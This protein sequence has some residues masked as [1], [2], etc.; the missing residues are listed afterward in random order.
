MATE[1][2]KILNKIKIAR[3]TRND[4]AKQWFRNQKMYDDGEYLKK[5]N[6]DQ[7]NVTSE[8]VYSLV[9]AMIPGLYYKN[10]HL[11]LSPNSEEAAAAKEDIVLLESLTN[12]EWRMMK[13]KKQIKAGLLDNMLAGHSWYKTGY[14][15]MSRKQLLKMGDFNR[16]IRGKSIYTVQIPWK[17]MFCNSYE[18]GNF[19]S[20]RWVAQRYY[21]T[22]KELEDNPKIKRGIEIKESDYKN[23]LDKSTIRLFEDVKD[24][25]IREQFYRVELF[26]YWD[27]QN[28]VVKTVA[29]GSK[30]ILYERPFPNEEHPFDLL[31]LEDASK[32][33][34]GISPVTKIAEE[35]QDYNK[36]RTQRANHRKRMKTIIYYD[37]DE[38]DDATIEDIKDSDDM[39]FVQVPGLI[40]KREAG[41]SPFVIA[42]APSIPGDWYR[43]DGTI[44]A[45]IR[46]TIALPE[47]ALGKRPQG[48]NTAYEASIIQNSM[49]LRTDDK[50]DSINEFL[51][52]VARKHIMLMT[53]YYSDEKGV[54]SMNEV[55]QRIIRNFTAKGCSSEVEINLNV[56]EGVPDDAVVRR[57]Q[58]LK[59]FQL[60]ANHPD[61]N[62]TPLARM[63]F[64]AFDRKDFDSVYQPG[65]DP[66]GAPG[67][68][69]MGY[70]VPGAFNKEGQPAQA[71][72]PAASEPLREA[73]S[74]AGGRAGGGR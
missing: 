68:P 16:N 57:E 32:H 18:A 11:Y 13:I 8:I 52:D 41:G 33:M 37:P 50:L 51:Y 38:I 58:A 54:P 42:D 21:R 72:G 35:A 2:E 49:R 45:N 44:K 3:S 74:K 53:K 19:D 30:E 1:S 23:A 62:E 59:F 63:V 24:K 26:D 56:A 61:F 46:E 34:F 14:V 28:Q 55:G 6:P 15:N 66:A 10:P 64:E 12:Q 48:V 40:Q 20:V 39:S 36:L 31:V 60:F 5:Y 25:Y 65:G 69:P 29:T 70:G 73:L 71:G 4:L 17:H 67:T 27:I 7:D 43:D 22:K 9:R 47:Y